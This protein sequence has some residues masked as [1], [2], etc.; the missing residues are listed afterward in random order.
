M[1]LIKQVAIY[2]FGLLAFL[3]DRFFKAVRSSALAIERRSQSRADEKRDA[4]LKTLDPSRIA[5]SGQ[6][7]DVILAQQARCAQG[8]GPKNY[9]HLRR[10]S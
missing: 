1:T 2:P 10:A 3:F 9:S 6:L 5:E 4:W 7:E 8:L